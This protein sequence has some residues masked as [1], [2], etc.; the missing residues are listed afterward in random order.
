MRIDCAGYGTAV[1]LVLCC[2]G[3][4][5]AQPGTGVRVSG[6][7]MQTLLAHSVPPTYPKEARAAH[8]SGAAVLRVRVGANGQ[9]ED[10]QPVSGPDVLAA[11]AEEAVCQCTYR[12]Y[13]LNGKPV[14]VETTV[15]VTFQVGSSTNRT[16]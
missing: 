1:V 16:R 14:A 6:S 9:V 13:L 11:A 5:S 12:P 10:A 4:A 7:G 8:V 2:V 15:T 3:S